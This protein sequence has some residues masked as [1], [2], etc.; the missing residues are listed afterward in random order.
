[1][2]R[3]PR[4]WP[5][6]RGIHRPPVNS[7]HKGQWRGALM[8]S[9]ICVWITGWVNNREAGDLRR[10]RAHYDVTVMRWIRMPVTSGISLGTTCMW[11][12]TMRVQ[13]TY[14]TAWLETANTLSVFSTIESNPCVCL[15]VHN[16]IST[17]WVEIASYF[18]TMW[19][20][21]THNKVS[22]LIAIDLLALESCCVMVVLYQ[23]SRHRVTCIM[24]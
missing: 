17:S 9:L 8:F 13:G 23:M 6:V 16:Y 5:F 4:Y 11:W 20:K 18:N 1:M 19:I 3:F 14:L 22:N 15:L 7:Q 10:Y 2:E 12:L 21:F 24:V